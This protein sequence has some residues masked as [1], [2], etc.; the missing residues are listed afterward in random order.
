[1]IDALLKHD[2]PHA[3][4]LQRSNV[5]LTHRQETGIIELGD[6]V[7][8]K[9]CKMTFSDRNA[10]NETVIKIDAADETITIVNHEDYIKQFNGKPFATGGTCDLLMFDGDNHKKVVFCDLG[11]YSEKYVV[12]KQKDSHKQ[13]SNSISRFLK[14][15]CGRSF[16]HQFSEKILM[17]GRRDPNINPEK[18]PLPARGDVIGSMRSFIVTPFSKSKYAISHEVV[19]GVDVSFIIVNFPEPYIW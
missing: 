13:V 8:C 2:L 4:G 5:L 10:C 16:I 12:K 14:Q 19:E 11:C 17:F 3:Y 1:M 15:P 9:S 18:T 7:A 6:Q